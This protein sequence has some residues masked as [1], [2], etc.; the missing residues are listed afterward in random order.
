MFNSTKKKGERFIAPKVKNFIY[1][2]IY[3]RRFKMKCIMLVDD[4]DVIRNI[5]AHTLGMHSYKNVIMA[6][7]GLEA[8]EIIKKE[9]GNIC[10]YI[11]D[12]N[13]PKMD[14]LTLLQEI[15]KIDK[16]HPIIMLTTETDKEK[17]NKA[18]DLGATGWIIKPFDSEKFIKVIDMYLRA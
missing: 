3:K 8:L 7:D 4:S 15:R 17:I 13:M 1:Y 10:M 14:G 2:K 11:L 16:T 18:K 12:V 6:R 9:S 5:V